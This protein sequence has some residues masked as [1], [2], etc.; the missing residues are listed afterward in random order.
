MRFFVLFLILVSSAATAQVTNYKL[1]DLDNET[2]SPGA[3]IAVS[4]KNNKNMVAY[5]AGKVMYSNDGGVTWKQSTFTFGETGSA[6]PSMT[7]DTKGNFYMVYSTSAF[8]D[9]FATSS[10]DDGKT[11]SV[12]FSISAPS[13]RQQYNPSIT[14]HPKKEEVMV[15]WTQTDQYGANAEDCTSD[16]MMVTGSG[17]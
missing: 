16:I 8:T 12:P 15:T 10:G 4:P 17:K 2:S 11:W 6:L 5:A 14:A 7:A 3:A 1:A 13:T 9:I